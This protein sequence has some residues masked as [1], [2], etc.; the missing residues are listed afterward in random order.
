MNDFTLGEP[1]REILNGH[2]REKNFSH[3]K[4]EWKVC[5]WEELHLAFSLNIALD[6]QCEIF[7]A[8][9][10]IT[11]PTSASCFARRTQIRGFLPEDTPQRTN[12][13]SL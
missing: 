2:A 7:Q 6:I 13:R 10:F 12:G 3:F 9:G 4:V 11:K 5:Q 1:F 8:T